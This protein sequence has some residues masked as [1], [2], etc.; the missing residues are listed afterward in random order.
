MIQYSCSVSGNGCQDSFRIVYGRNLGGVATPQSYYRDD[1]P[2]CPASGSA[3]CQEIWGINRGE[4]VDISLTFPQ[5]QTGFDISPLVKNF[6]LND[7]GGRTAYFSS[8]IVRTS[9]FHQNFNFTVDNFQLL[10]TYKHSPW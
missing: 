10:T 8:S 9:S 1:I 6:T 4:F 3:V 5:H 7:K 2:D